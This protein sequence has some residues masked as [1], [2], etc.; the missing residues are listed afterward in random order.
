M[1]LPETPRDLERADFLLHLQR[2]FHVSRREA[3]TLLSTWMA[4]FA[5]ASPRSEQASD[6][7][8]AHPGENRT[9]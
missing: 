4:D 3:R 6:G 5:L 2:S 8:Q 9:G 1:K 7:P